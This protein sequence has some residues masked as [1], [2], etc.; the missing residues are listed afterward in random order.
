MIRYTSIKFSI[1]EIAKKI[2]DDTKSKIAIPWKKI[3][4]FR[5]RAIH[6]YFDINLGV[7]WNTILTDIPELKKAILENR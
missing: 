1:G 6:N 7:V 3:I 4:G 5:D 2:S